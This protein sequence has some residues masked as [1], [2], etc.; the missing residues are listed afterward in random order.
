MS[1]YREDRIRNGVKRIKAARGVS[2]PFSLFCC[3]HLF[4]VVFSPDVCA[5]PAGFF[6]QA[7]GFGDVTD[8]RL[9]ETQGATDTTCS[10][11]DW[12]R[13]K[14]VFFC[15]LRRRKRRRLRQKR[16]VAQKVPQRALRSSRVN[17]AIMHSLLFGGV[18]SFVCASSFGCLLNF[19]VFPLISRQNKKKKNGRASNEPSRALGPSFPVRRGCCELLTAIID[20]CVF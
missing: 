5:R 8:S 6:L 1:L 20:H 18:I 15:A 16:R 7:D 19:G 13:G 2:S 14:Y 11:V 4:T 3:L 9:Q 10:V 17:N 12:P